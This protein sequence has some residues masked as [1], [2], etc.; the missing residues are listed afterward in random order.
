MSPGSLLE[1]AAEVVDDFAAFGITALTT[2]RTFGTLST[3]GSDP[4]GEVMGRWN[5][6]TAF[7]ADRGASRLA[8]SPQVHGAEVHVH[9]AGWNG[10]L[11]ALAGDGHVAPARGTAMAVTVADC[12]PV[13]LAHP[14]GAAGVIHSG[15]KGTAA[16]IVERGI[17]L[18]AGR[19]IPASELRVHLGP[20]I[21]GRCY[22]VSGE[23]HA[24]LTGVDPGRPA[25]VDL[26]ALIAGHARAAG[27]T[28]IS[29]SPLCT[30]CDNHTLYSHRCGDAGRQAGII[31]A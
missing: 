14:S 17:A 20:A 16:R 30:R 7:A 10:W 8:T 2:G 24:R 19:G 25:T 27:V 1:G 5:A 28:H 12:V 31:V 29:V 21:C 18:L 9:G 3:S 6:I 22:E 4:V 23:V 26:R 13:F 15:W 11:R